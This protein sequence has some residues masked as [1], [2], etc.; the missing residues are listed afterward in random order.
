MASIAVILLITV[1]S[2]AWSG[3]AHRDQRI[4]HD[5]LALGRKLPAGATVAV[6][7]RSA[8]GVAT[9]GDFA[10]QSYLSRWQD[11]HLLSKPETSSS[12]FVL[13]PAEQ[14]DEPA[15]FVLEPSA[16]TRYRL[17]RRVRLASEAIEAETIDRISPASNERESLRR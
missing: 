1:L 16:L 7:N 5:T 15:G 8:N 2:V 12:Q 17:Y 9:F 10:F 3:T 13:V 6:L 4:L 11:I 14:R